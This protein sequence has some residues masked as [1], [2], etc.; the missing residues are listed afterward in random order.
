WSPHGNPS[1]KRLCLTIFPAGHCSLPRVGRD[2]RLQEPPARRLVLLWTPR[3]YPAIGQSAPLT[4]TAPG[5]NRAAP[6]PSRG[7]ST[8]CAAPPGFVPGERNRASA[9]TPLRAVE[10]NIAQNRNKP[11]PQPP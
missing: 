10:Q 9:S 5:H 7:P 2:R 6:P 1:P 11:H 8:R 4:R 3:T